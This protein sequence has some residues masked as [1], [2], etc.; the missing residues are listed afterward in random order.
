MIMADITESMGTFFRGI[1]DEQKVGDQPK[2]PAA[3]CPA[4]QKKLGSELILEKPPAPPLRAPVVPASE[5]KSVRLPTRS[6]KPIKTKPLNMS[7][8]F[9]EALCLTINS[10]GQVVM[11]RG[12]K[13]QAEKSPAEKPQV[14]KPLVSPTAEQLAK[15]ERYRAR[16]GR[17][18]Q[19]PL[20]PLQK[21]IEALRAEV[22][23]LRLQKIVDEQRIV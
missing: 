19:D 4:S 17:F 6:G 1:C 16:R 21:E 7:P 11:P 5:R 14:E 8:A 9:K 13:C 20:N 15:K 3:S 23:Q 18:K 12:E 22:K 10:Q 2:L